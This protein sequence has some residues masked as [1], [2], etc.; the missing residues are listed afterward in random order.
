MS[1]QTEFRGPEAPAAEDTENAAEQ[2]RLTVE[3]SGQD[4][5]RIQDEMPVLPEGPELDQA[6][7]VNATIEAGVDPI[8]MRFAQIN[9]TY[10]PEPIAYRTFTYLNSVSTGVTGPEVYAAETDPTEEGINLARWNIT[11]ALR[12][13]RQM[14]LAGRK[15]QYVTARCPWEMCLR[16]DL[17]DIVK[18]LAK[19]Q[20]LSPETICLEFP[21]GLMR[22]ADP[23][24][25]ARIRK[26]ILDMKLLK[27]RTMVTG[28]GTA[29]IS[30]A[31]LFEIPVDTFLLD[32]AITSMSDSRSKGAN[33]AALVNFLKSFSADVIADGVYND[34]QINALTKCDCRA[35]IPSSGYQG[36]V[37]HGSLRMRLEEAAAQ[38]AEE[39]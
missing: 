13:A 20:G 27:V 28:I 17:Y 37:K 32:P 9:S 34:N 31:A 14:E 3:S 19:E 4:T 35:Y 18:G 29:D 1:G 11:H 2:E 26:S 39:E 38:H 6:R 33:V 16:D 15:I 36:K 30:P 24:S 12:A 21:S 25:R 23:E 7:L 8:E 10:P 22:A 5:D